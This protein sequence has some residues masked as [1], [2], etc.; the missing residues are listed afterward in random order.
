METLASVKTEQ[1]IALVQ[2]AF[3]DFLNGNIQ[4]IIDTCSD[5]VEWGS[6]ENDVT[7]ISGMYHGKV[8]VARF[9]QTLGENVNYTLFDPREYFSDGNNVFVK[10]RHEG[11][12]KSTGK[13]FAHDFIMQFVVSNGKISYFF[14][15]VDT[16]DQVKAYLN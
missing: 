13:T 16:Y 6:Y 12:V 11:V 7:P 3:A 1:N 5:D 2:S 8:G 9:F 10:G 15:W 14:V 4:A